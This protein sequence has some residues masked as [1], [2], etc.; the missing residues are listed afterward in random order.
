MSELQY[1]FRH[2]DN[3]SATA[4]YFSGGEKLSNTAA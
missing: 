4:T 2:R 1:S 3:V